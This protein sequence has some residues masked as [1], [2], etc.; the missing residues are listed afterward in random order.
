MNILLNHFKHHAKKLRLVILLLNL[1]HYQEPYLFLHITNN[2]VVKVCAGLK[3]ESQIKHS[4]L[5]TF[6][7]LITLVKPR[8]QA[9]LRLC[10]ENIDSAFIPC[11]PT[12]FQSLL[13]VV[14][15]FEVAILDAISAGKVPTHHLI[16]ARRQHLV[17]LH[18]ESL[19]LF[20]HSVSYLRTVLFFFIIRKISLDFAMLSLHFACKSLFLAV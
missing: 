19:V 13:I 6:A 11:S 1:F 14:N 9:N 4:F 2:L 3:S 18:H 15:G 5:N 7:L 16:L 17:C 10:N 12:V 8:C 20:G